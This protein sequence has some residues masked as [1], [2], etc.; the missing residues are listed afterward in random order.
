MTYTF[1]AV[2]RR[3]EEGGYWAE[4]PDLEGCF[5]QGDTFGETVESISNGLETHLASMLECGLDIPEPSK[6]QAADGEV[7][8]VA[9]SLAGA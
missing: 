8:Y 6:V 9:A 7:V 3:D 4:V 1:A 5:G 2:I